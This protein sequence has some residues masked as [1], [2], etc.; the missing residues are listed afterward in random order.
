ML[1]ILKKKLKESIQFKFLAVVFVV[2]IA[3]TLSASAMLA[4]NQRST[5]KQSL[6]D[7]GQ[8]LGA[9]M[10]QLSMNPIILKDFAQLDSIVKEVNKDAEIAYAVVLDETGRPLTTLGASIDEK[11]ADIKDIMASLPKDSEL[12]TVV[13]AIKKA[14]ALEASFPITL[15]GNTLGAVLLGMS[16]YKINQQITST[17]AFVLGVNLFVAILLGTA[18]YISSKRIILDPIAKLTEISRRIAQGEIF[19][20]VEVTSADEIGRLMQSFG[21]MSSYLRNIG[22][23]AGEIAKG[24]LRREVARRSESDYIGKSFE[25]MMAGLQDIV[26]R[27]RQNSHQISGASSQLAV[28]AEEASKNN[29]SS[30]A[31]IEE[32]TATMHEMAANTSSVAKNTQ[33]Q[34]ASVGET[35]SSIEQMIVSI[36]RV[37]ENVKKLVE[38][39]QKSREATGNGRKAVDKSTAGMEEIDKTIRRVAD[40]IG[41]LSERIE[42][43]GKIVEVIDD[44]AE[45]TNLLALN[46]AIEAAKAGDQG[47]GFAVVADE[48]RKLAERSAVSTQEI[49]ELIRGIQKETG[50][51]VKQMDASLKSVQVELDEGRKD[52]A[53]TL[54]N[55]EVSVE[56]V[57]KYATEIGI[58]TDE[59]SAGGDQ[60][61]KAIAALND[62][63]QNISASAEQQ[64][65]GVEQVAKSIERIR[66]MIQQNTSSSTELSASAEQLA[67][68]SKTL[69][70]AVG[71][72][73]LKEE[74]V[75]ANAA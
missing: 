42:N 49:N 29:E 30:A 52:V 11:Q 10:T 57:A 45:Q 55:I 73:Q 26:A 67:T 28:L 38:I 31:A 39:T 34:A 54:A 61:I 19:Q 12:L 66:D 51:A 7:K 25:K 58:A 59:Q 23:A 3:M 6:L 47:L 2:T 74:P 60:I 69:R 44:I 41:T 1:N 18:L 4:Q 70:E 13:S 9:Y 8:S 75:M 14:G 64:A 62:L 27:V 33:S 68:Q 56:E 46:A 43:I 17:I 50:N 20:Q 15:E 35:S 5:L 53:S 71:R 32:I 21:E 48:V 36:K 40:T 16:Q 63:T 22:E 72:F 37:A 65:A 24:E